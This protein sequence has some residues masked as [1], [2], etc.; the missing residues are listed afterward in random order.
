[1]CT[2]LLIAFICSVLVILFQ[3]A[4]LYGLCVDLKRRDQEALDSGIGIGINLDPEE[5]EFRA[6]VKMVQSQQRG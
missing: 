3:G 5:A 2:L 6:A 1:M 4:V